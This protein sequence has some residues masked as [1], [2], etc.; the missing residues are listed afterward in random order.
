MWVWI[1]VLVRDARRRQAESTPPPS[2]DTRSSRDRRSGRPS[3]SAGSSIWMTR[4]AGA[5]P[6]PPP[7]RGCASA[8]CAAVSE[9]GWSSRTKDHCSMV[10]GPVSMPFIGFAG[11]RLRVTRSSRTV[12]GLRAADVAVDDRRLD[13]ARAVA[14]HPAVRGE[15][16][17]P[18]S[19]S[20]KYSTM[21]LRSASPCTSTS[22]PMLL[23]PAHGR[24][25]SPPQACS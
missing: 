8:I 24:R 11:E 17:S 5:S 19:C 23:L 16:D 22:R 12:I 3:R 21:S 9:R 4:D 18:R 1:C 20:P 6:G 25:R 15:G 2:R 13:A 14:L 7:R 10:T